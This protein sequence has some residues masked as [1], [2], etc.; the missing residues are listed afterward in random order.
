MTEPQELA[1]GTYPLEPLPLGHVGIELDC[2]L[3]DGVPDLPTFLW[4]GNP[5]EAEHYR[6][7]Y[8]VHIVPVSDKG[9]N[10]VPTVRLSG[11]HEDV[12]N[13]LVKYFDGD[14]EYAAQAYTAVMNSVSTGSVVS[15]VGDYYVDTR[16][17]IERTEGDG[18]S[19]PS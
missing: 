3:P 8:D 16:S 13:A 18:S 4:E 2:P 9:P 15:P 14:E 1:D 19:Q 12:R 6:N 5:S 7:L 11:F 10:G 17:G